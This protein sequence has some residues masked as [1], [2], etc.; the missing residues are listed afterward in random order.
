MDR[1][2]AMD[3]PPNNRVC[4]SEQQ[5][6]QEPKFWDQQSWVQIQALSFPAM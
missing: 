3:A 2:I 4:G 1:S 6:E 5:R